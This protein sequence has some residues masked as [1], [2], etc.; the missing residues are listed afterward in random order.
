MLRKLLISL[1]TLSLSTSATLGL[2]NNLDLKSNSKLELKYLEE[3]ILK[4]SKLIKSE[5]EYKYQDKIYRDKNT[6]LNEHL[7]KS[8]ITVEQTVSNPNKIIKN[9][10]T[11]ELDGSKIYNNNSKDMVKVYKNALGKAVL[12]NCENGLVVGCVKSIKDP[13]T[14][15]ILNSQIERTYDSFA[16]KGLFVPMYSYDGQQWY[17][18]T[19]EAEREFK[20]S[21]FQV[22]Q[23]L[24]YFYNGKYY[25]AFNKND[26]D[27]LFNLFTT[28]YRYEVLDESLISDPTVLE[29]FKKAF[30][31]NE[32]DFVS[33]FFDNLKA[34]MENNERVNDIIKVEENQYTIKLTSFGNNSH[35]E[36]FTIKQNFDNKEKGEIIPGERVIVDGEMVG[37]KDLT[38]VLKGKAAANLNYKTVVD[39]LR[40]TSSWDVDS[41][42]YW[43]GCENSKGKGK[44]TNY[45][46]SSGDDFKISL[47][48]PDPSKCNKIWSS[49]PHLG[50]Y[51]ILNTEKNT[52]VQLSSKNS[53]DKLWSYL[54]SDLNMNLDF[55]KILTDR[56]NNNIDLTQWEKVSSYSTE[57]KNELYSSIF[58]QLQKNIF[59][60]S[61]DNNKIIKNDYLY[62]SFKEQQSGM[63]LFN[64]SYLNTKKLFEDSF[65]N[66][67]II[68]QNNRAT[69]TWQGKAFTENVD[70]WKNYFVP[71]ENSRNKPGI[72]LIPRYYSYNRVNHENNKINIYSDPLGNNLAETKQKAEDIVFNNNLGILRKSYLVYDING[73]E[74]QI[75][76][77]TKEAAAQELKKQISLDYKL[78]HKNELANYKD[79]FIDMNNLITDGLYSVYKF[80]ASNGNMMYFKDYNSAKAI[81]ENQIS[82]IGGIEEKW[83][84]YY[85]YTTIIKGVKRNYYWDTNTDIKQ[86]S[87]KIY[88]DIKGKN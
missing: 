14:G 23:S 59:Q 8:P 48:V 35:A 61:L 76:Q 3:D 84:S 85:I 80:K 12:P 21:E 58:D 19:F 45:I 77:D 9:Y 5:Y 56:S 73:K 24:F 86:L 22:G 62:G 26:M 34:H 46:F 30:S 81:Y 54:N 75:F 57:I 70:I 11:N 64:Y 7:Q 18:S 47:D 42:N 36:A 78:V 52:K 25:N 29:P 68:D 43:R 72:E 82:L 69:F 83:V 53:N 17:E 38:I 27:V 4:N 20:K 10:A 88:L 32:K 31:F 71:L 13:V 66:T 1:S 49:N 15:E 74:K 37:Y 55:D 67:A 87:N 65:K 16:N 41:Y 39:R 79:Q 2:N 51:E 60:S 40:N 33:Y 63:K 28:G 50:I 44:K 6:I